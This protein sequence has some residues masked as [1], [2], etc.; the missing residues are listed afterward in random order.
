MQ[1]QEALLNTDRR[2]YL[3]A[4]ITILILLFVCYYQIFYQA[5]FL[6]DMDAVF[7]YDA[8][9]ETAKGNGWRPDKAWGVSFFYGDPAVFHPWSILSFFYKLFPSSKTVYNVTVLLFFFL[10]AFSNYYW[11][12]RLL[13]DLDN[14]RMILPMISLLV[15]FNPGQ[16]RYGHERFWIPLSICAPLLLIV[17]HNYLQK[18]RFTHL[19][20]GTLLFFFCFFLGS[21]PCV[22]QLFILEVVF[23][24]FY[25]LYYKP[26]LKTFSIRIAIIN[27]FMFLWLLLLGSWIFYSILIEQS[28][29]DY[30]RAVHRYNG[31][32][33]SIQATFFSLLNYLIEQFHTGWFPESTSLIGLEYTFKNSWRNCSVI[34][35]FVLIYFVFNKSK[36]F[37]EYAAKWMLVFITVFFTFVI[38]NVPFAGYIFERIFKGYGANKYYV[39]GYTLQVALIAMF[40]SHIRDRHYIT[41]SKTVRFLQ[42][43]LAVT[44]AIIYTILIVISTLI[45][46][47]HDLLYRF[48]MRLSD[49][50]IPANI[51]IYIKGYSKDYL[52]EI[53]RINIK[54]YK[55]GIS[56][57]TTVYYIL[58]VIVVLPFI[59]DKWLSRA[60]VMS[61]YLVIVLLLHAIFLSWSLY[62]LNRAPFHWN[63]DAASN[64]F[65]TTDRF[66]FV[67]EYM[68]TLNKDVNILKNQWLYETGEVKVKPRDIIHTPGLNLTGV[69]VLSS[70]AEK[71]TFLAFNND[72]KERI[73]EFRD[74][75]GGGPLHSSQLFDL[76][77]VTYYYSLSEFYNIPDNLKLYLRTK[78]VYIYKNLSTWPYYYLAEDTQTIDNLS[79]LAAIK[80]LKKGTA[81]IYDKDLKIEPKGKST[82]N[83]TFFSFGKMEFDYSGESDNLL[84]VAD[85]WHPFWKASNGSKDLSVIKANGIFK[86]VVLPKGS[87]AVKLYFDTSKY[88]PGIYIAIVSWIIFLILWVVYYNRPS[89]FDKRLNKICNVSPGDWS[90]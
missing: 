1:H 24:V 10:A 56:W 6:T 19:F 65:K 30:V 38:D 79:Q 57:I 51:D 77:A 55:S 18:P 7:H 75:E 67:H 15:V 41:E 37:W 87:Y 9:A 59:R 26:P 17:L 31:G 43:L 8:A 89:N 66:Y 3:L 2:H 71:Y 70:D 86:G 52:L 39:I 5:D 27:A 72:G 21:Y 84:I 48:I 83:M 45:L 58:T 20:L 25:Y 22:N 11:L 69:N 40:I 44:L 68:S 47:N 85:E 34:F 4:G 14:N 36:C 50:A 62:P 63:K 53:V 64:I 49:L 32:L 12:K 46:T 29:I 28:L 60:K 76:G 90:N 13:P 42:R 54:I 73:K 80:T 78:D 35:P 16:L 61:N 74:L 81:Y 23:L 33:Q 82:I 88:V